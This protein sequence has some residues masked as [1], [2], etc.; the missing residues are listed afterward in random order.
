MCGDLTGAIPTDARP[1]IFRVADDTARGRPRC[2]FRGLGV[3][4]AGPGRGGTDK[5]PWKAIQIVA[6]EVLRVAAGHKELST[7]LARAVRC[8]E[9]SFF[10]AWTMSMTTRSVWIARR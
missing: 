2:H 10:L 1:C 7:S 5:V 3:N 6:T 4:V 9:V 8:Y